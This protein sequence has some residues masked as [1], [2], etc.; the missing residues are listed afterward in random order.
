MT[1]HELAHELDKIYGPDLKAV[2]LY[3]SAADGEYSQKFS[4]VNVF[5][6]LS[7][8]TPAMLARANKLVRKWIRRGNPPPHFFDPDHIERSLDVFPIEFLDMLDRHK[9]LIGKDPFE[10]ISIDPANLRHQCESELKGKLI[11]LRTLYTA[12]CHHPKQIARLMVETFPTFLAA[13]RG[14][15]R[16]LSVTPPKDARA[17]AELIGN[18]VGI[19]P[20]IFFDIIDIRRGAG[21]LPRRAE[22]LIAFERYLTELA[23][24][25]KYV[26]EMQCT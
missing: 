4:D 26:D 7:A 14:T 16:L 21:M 15:L 8:V 24:L 11:H 23:A 18:R 3:G 25:T 10:K 2:V 20:T 6:V 5:C 1:P 19:N 12:N 9:T 13:M 22:A 17:V